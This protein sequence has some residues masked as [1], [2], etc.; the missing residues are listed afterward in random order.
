MKTKDFLIVAL[1][2]LAVLLLPLVAM[3]FTHEVNWTLSDFV[4]MWVVLTIPTL[5]FRILVT[6]KW[7]SLS[8]RLGA[9]LALVTGFL[10]TWVNLAVQIIG[11]RNPANLF[12]FGV[13][14]LGLVG[15]GLSRFHP[16]GLARTAFAAAGMTLLIPVVAVL[17]W[18]SDFSPGVLPVFF[19]N[20]VIAV[21]FAAAGLLF[22][23]AAGQSQISPGGA[24]PA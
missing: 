4:V 13:V 20:T 15:V 11:D 16:T 14:L 1:F 23:H 3:Q 12:Y 24:L 8:Y 6:R 17:A 10:I 19:G 5:L 22:R 9:A 2:P 21:L 7:A 18:P